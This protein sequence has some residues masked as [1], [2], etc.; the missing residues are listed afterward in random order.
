MVR[1]MLVPSKGHTVKIAPGVRFVERN[2]S[3]GRVFYMKALTE[4]VCEETFADGRPC[5]RYRWVARNL[6]TG[7]KTEYLVTDA[8]LH[9]APALFQNYKE[10]ERF[11]FPSG[12]NPEN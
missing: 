9:Y 12:V 7:R 6:E 3:I 1:G 10:S 11:W 8:Y 2:R 4:P 5:L